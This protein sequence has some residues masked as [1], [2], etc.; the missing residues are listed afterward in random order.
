MPTSRSI[1]A[2]LITAAALLVLALVLLQPL[3]HY[4]FARDHGMY[5]TVAETISRGGMPYADAWDVKTPGIFLVFRV[6]LGLFGRVMWGVRVLELLFLAGTALALW[7]LGSRLDTGRWSG[8]LAA[9]TF[10]LFLG[11]N[12]DYW[13]TAQAESFLMLPLVLGLD[14][15]VKALLEGRRRPAL[16]AAALSGL[17]L[18]TVFVFKFPNVLPVAAVLPLLTMRRNTTAPP[19]LALVALFAAGGLAAPLLTAAWFALGGAL[20]HLWETLFVFAPR[21]AGITA[22]GGLV[23][24]GLKVFAGFF[25]PG[26]GLILPKWLCLAGLLFC[27]MKGR[28]PARLVPP[29]W[30]ALS[31]LVIW[32]QGKFF[33]YHYLPLYLPVALLAGVAADR[34]A[35]VV[36][37][38][39]KGDESARRT[40][41]ALVAAG[42]LMLPVLLDAGHLHRHRKATLAAA[43]VTAVGKDLSIYRDGTD[44]SLAADLEV[45]KYLR[46]VTGPDE[47]VFIWGYETLVH[48]LADRRPACRFITHQP[49]ASRW[50]MPGWREEAMAA[51]RQAPPA[52]IL[53]LRRDSM[54]AVT[55]S[56]RDSAGL[57]AEFPELE[58][59][60]AAHYD[61]ETEI[62][63]FIIH[64]RKEAP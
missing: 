3:L 6:A 27:L 16:I 18:G 38:R 9:A 22:S 46:H 8:L 51:L 62:E 42:L 21:Y 11:H 28:G 58:Q 57:L 52:R 36:G 5:V 48:F 37:G 40:T 13:H 26:Q 19:R 24:H 1:I 59:F 10:I 35:L 60:I 14:Q 53:V 15:A 50:Q 44:F 39:V 2:C 29:L 4:P 20:G 43:P 33:L 12:L 64:R 47:T 54:P 45:A 61:L 41:V 56:T 31:L 25:M 32:V 34:V 23:L 30:F 49:L 7:R 63:D 55:G 17:C